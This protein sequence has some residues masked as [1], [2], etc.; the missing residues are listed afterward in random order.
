MRILLALAA[1][2]A[3]PLS[4]DAVTIDTVLVG[5]P[6]NAP[7]LQPQGLFGR[8]TATYRIGET[9][10]T[11]A[12]YTE[13]LNAVADA[14]PYALYN[15]NMGFSTKGGI[16]QSGSS[17]SYAYA[18]KPDVLVEDP[19]GNYTYTYGDKP[20]VFVSWY[21]TIRFANWL[22]N[23]QG[24]GNTETG[25][26]T[27]LGGTPTPSNADS[28]S[29]SAGAKWFLPSEDEW[30][31][32]AY[33]DGSTSAYF[34]YPTG[35]N[36]APNNN[37]P[38]ADTG[39]SANYI[40]GVNTTTGNLDYPYTPAGAYPLSDSRYGTLDQAGS[41]WEWNETLISAGVRGR[42]GGAWN[43]DAT[44]LIR[45]NQGSQTATFHTDS[46]GFRVASIPD[47]GELLGDFNGDGTVDAAD[48]VVWRKMGGTVEQY[49][50]WRA[51]FGMSSPGGGSVNIHAVPE[52]ASILALLSGSF[53]VFCCRRPNR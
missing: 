47:P 46:V 8:V 3:A 7:D 52:P 24:S 29:R 10:V 23:G 15:T 44:T 19:G 1:A 31:K 37:L 39:N 26:Y 38:A 13:F 18:V 6:S 25:A 33:F 4:V 12:Q 41:V 32:A 35:S 36:T 5:N 45:S 20:V 40:V 22:H 2:L 49:N 28:I 30:Y 51:N 48:Y 21:D 14:D 9:E 17:G 16:T 42:R 27:L 11:N 53:V 43:S 50:Q 34:D